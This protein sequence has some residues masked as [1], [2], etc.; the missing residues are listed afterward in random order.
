MNKLGKNQEAFLF[1]IDFEFNNAV[2]L[3]KDFL[4]P[5]KI[6][7]SFN[8]FSNSKQKIK[9]KNI[10]FKKFPTSLYNFQIAYDK[11]QKE[12]NAGNTYLLNLSFPAKIETNLGLK[13]IF[14]H[15]K[16]KYKLYFN[17]EFVVFSPETFIK[18][19]NNK[20][21]SYPMKG[22]ID[23]DIPNA[24]LKILSDRKESAEHNT[25]VDLIRNDL[26][27]IAK[28]VK[29]EKFRYIDK[30]QTNQKNLLQVSSEI[31]GNLPENYN[32]Q[33]GNIFEKLLPA[34][35]ISGAPKKK[36]IE[37]IKYVENYSRNFYTGI[38]GYFDGKNL[39]SFVMIRFIEKQGN[40][41]FFKSGG[42]ITSMSKL[43]SEYR[44]MIDK[45]YI[46]V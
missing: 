21:F 19:Q 3:T 2:I 38:A 46:P 17:G 13:D 31:S 12:I 10:D 36:T 9:K 40:E 20:I 34:G 8:K 4:D 41:L 33:I 11:V 42:G 18:I 32:E 35:S 16:A 26:N 22:T 7:F 5:Y 45:I 29:V 27:M 39:D 6:K 14:R 24:E 44:E 28:N 30:I 23:A 37:I 25:I 43:K 1:I 15:S